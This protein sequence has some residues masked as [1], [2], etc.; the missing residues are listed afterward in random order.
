MYS[1]IPHLIDSYFV[2]IR[3]DCL[4]KHSE[5]YFHAGDTV[6]LSPE[7]WAGDVGARMRLKPLAKHRRTIRKNLLSYKEKL[8]SEN[9]GSL[10]GITSTAEIELYDFET[11][12]ACVGDDNHGD[13]ACTAGVA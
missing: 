2:R 12:V 9:D 3:N 13:L 5:P 11:R 8:F 7:G 10:A 1:E 6:L 4:M